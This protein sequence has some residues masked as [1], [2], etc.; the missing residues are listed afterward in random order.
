MTQ[1]KQQPAGRATDP[2]VME[3][4][5]LQFEAGEVRFRSRVREAVAAR[6][7]ASFMNA[8]KWAELQAAVQDE[9]PFAP[10]YQRQD[11]LEDPQAVPE[12]DVGSWG[13]WWFGEFIEPIW[14]I[15]WLRIIPYR[16]EHVGALVPPRLN[17]DCREPLKAILDRLSIPCRQDAR[18]IWVY[19]YAPAG[20]ATLTG[21][22]E[23]IT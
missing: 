16:W 11:L 18:S 15:E 12:S 17:A 13:G 5:R 19:G 8:T 6:G 21:P 4:R 2:E 23:G 22:G 10:A 20:P 9:L 7:L 14:S 1:K 3:H